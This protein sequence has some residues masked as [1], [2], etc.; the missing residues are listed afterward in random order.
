M[1]TDI[2]S[3]RKN[4]PYAALLFLSGSVFLAAAIYLWLNRGDLDLIGF[5][6]VAGL[7]CTGSALI[8]LFAKRNLHEPRRRVWDLVTGSVACIFLTIDRWSAGTSL[9]RI[10]GVGATIC[11]LAVALWLIVKS[12]AAREKSLPDTARNPD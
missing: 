11:G 10:P 5:W 1:E 2:I 9:Q 7:Y 6:L 3:P 12:R 8:E 4:T